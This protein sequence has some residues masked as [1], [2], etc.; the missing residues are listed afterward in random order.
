MFTIKTDGQRAFITGER[1]S[2]LSLQQTIEII[3][4]LLLAQ[5]GRY[6]GLS[7]AHFLVQLKPDPEDRNTIVI[8]W[9]FLLVDLLLW[10]QVPLE[11]LAKRDRAILLWL[12]AEV[13]TA[14]L[15]YDP[16][17]G[18]ACLDWLQSYRLD[19][20]DEATQLDYLLEFIWYRTIKWA[21]TYRP[22]KDSFRRLPALL[23]G[24]K[25]GTPAY[26]EF[27]DQLNNFPDNLEP[28]EMLASYAAGSIMSRLGLKQ[29]ARR[30]AM[31]KPKYNLVV[32]LLE[33]AC[34]GDLVVYGKAPT[35]N[36]IDQYEFQATGDASARRAGSQWFN[37]TYGPEQRF[38]PDDLASHWWS[39][40]A[41]QGCYQQTRRGLLV[42]SVIPPDNNPV[43]EQFIERARRQSVINPD[44]ATIA[45]FAWYRMQQHTACFI[46]FW[47]F[48]TQPG[49]S[50]LQ[51]LDLLYD[52]DPHSPPV[53]AEAAG[54]ELGKLN[55]WLGRDDLRFRCPGCNFEDRAWGS[56]CPGGY[57]I[58]CPYCQRPGFVEKHKQQR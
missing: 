24:F 5:Y 14:L 38:Q 52:L 13:E 28:G 7:L 46:D 55:E 2:L 39:F 42:M 47:H 34:T 32:S 29:L 56:R 10:R 17:L 57:E 33:V 25:A 21:T 11:T 12:E 36:V 23:R 45:E 26:Q 8:Y 30:K 35:G 18:Q 19:V 3:V 15:N 6:M 43:L 54:I 4:K 27:W 51:E 49:P 41:S 37:R 31:S 44:L 20:G 1:S 40:T 9:P 53:I 22:G 16:E 50:T 48:P 58:I